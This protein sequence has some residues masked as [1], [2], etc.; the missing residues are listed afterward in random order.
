MRRRR[1]STIATRRHRPERHLDA[2]ESP[3]CNCTTSDRLPAGLMRPSGDAVVLSTEEA[4]DREFRIDLDEVRQSVGRAEVITVHFPY[5]HETLL[6]DTRKSM[7]EPPMAR[8][9][10]SVNSVDER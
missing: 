5:F 3:C 8:I 4:M 1:G 9:R 10:P 7:S 6:L 2:P